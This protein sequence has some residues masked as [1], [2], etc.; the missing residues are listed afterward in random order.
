[1]WR[2]AGAQTREGPAEGA[3]RWTA[4]RSEARQATTPSPR[5]AA[6]SPVVDDDTTD[7]LTPLRRGLE[8]FR[9]AHSESVQPTQRLISPLLDLWSLAA[10]VDHTT[11]APIEGLLTA[12]SVRTTTTSRELFACLDQVEATLTCHATLS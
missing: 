10:A 5:P 9:A 7:R 1:M 4:A 12:F 8:E 2:R 6:P 11:A 3:N